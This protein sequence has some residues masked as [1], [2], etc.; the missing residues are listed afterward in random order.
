MIALKQPKKFNKTTL[1]LV[2]SATLPLGVNGAY[3]A[4]F[5]ISGSS[6]T[7]QTLGSG[8]GQTG[9]INP[10][11]S[12][13]VSGSTVA[14]TVSGNNATLTNLG[15]LK[16]TGTGRAVRDNTGVTGLLINNGSSTNATALMQ[17]ADAD[18]IQMNKSPA[19]VT[20]NN[21]GVMTSLNASAGGAQ[22]VDFNAILSGANTIN[23]Y[24]GASMAAYEADAVRTGVNGVVYNAG[25]IKAVTTTGS[26]SD[27]VDTQ[28]NSGAQIT[29]DTTGLIE[30]GRHG[31]TGG[32]VDKLTSFTTQINNKSGGT[33]KG[34]N[35]S[36]INIDGF[37]ANQILTLTNAG[38]IIGN[39]VTGDGD[40]VDSDGLVNIS[41]TGVI[42]SLNAY[43]ASGL[44]FSEGITAGGG[45][46]T[47]SGVIEG[48]V[49]SGSS[50]TVGRGITLAGNDITSGALA[51]TREAIYGPTT[52][53]NQSG[54][55]IR[56][57]SDS[58][59]YVDGPRS[60]FSVT[61]NNN[62]GATIRGGGLINAAVRTGADDDTL[63]N[64]GEIDGTSSG[65]AIDMGAG[66]N[67]LK[68]TGGAASIKGN[69]NGGS[70]GH[71]TMTVDLGTGNSFTY[72][73]SIS[74]F[75]TVEI[76]S[77]DTTFSGNNTYTGK[78]HLSGG[79]LTLAGA[80]RIAAGSELV[81][82]GGALHIANAHSANAQTFSS[83]SLEGDSSIDLDASSIT[84][85]SLGGIGSNARLS[86]V[87]Y[88]TA[89]SPYF[90]FRFLGNETGDTNFMTL[91]SNTQINGLAATYSFD[92]TYTNVSAVPLPLP[93]A[94]MLSGVS[95]LGAFARRRHV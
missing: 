50:N 7:A 63:N 18:V 80:N 68:I 2:L 59:I 29:N 34:N 10:G 31:I 39:G 65:K 9:M 79:Q 23:N 11:A 72:T 49:T 61:I 30:G 26:S 35:G 89:T 82:G 71:N 47:N 94:L 52:I 81:L 6:T 15:Q 4:S 20:L 13:T 60:G 37:N 54:G 27:G 74:N 8:A 75:D 43:S 73:E 44:G 87:N 76:K 12:L 19:S 3:A 90:A 40:G 69:I 92:G 70:G 41:N 95:A 42:R 77:G 86:V 78:T 1:S 88:S 25:S 85:N 28:N 17:T 93:L 22:V 51:G 16:Q 32:A 45:T 83:L 66:N 84:F 57:E 24:A 58:G 14:V 5:T 36:G 33:I 38:T 91:I 46:I 53:T 21:Y 64:A 62:A 67:L 55:L 56:G 48:L